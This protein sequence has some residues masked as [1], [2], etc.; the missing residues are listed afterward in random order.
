LDKCIAHLNKLQ[1]H[2]HCPEKECKEQLCRIYLSQYNIPECIKCLENYNK[3]DSLYM[4]K[5][6]CKID[7]CAKTII[8]E[9]QSIPLLQT[10]FVI[11]QCIIEVKTNGNK[12]KECFAPIKSILD[13]LPK[14]SST[15][16]I[17]KF[18]DIMKNGGEY[19]KEFNVYNKQK[20]RLEYKFTKAVLLQMCL[21]KDC[22]QK[23][24]K[25]AKEKSDKTLGAYK[26][27]WKIHKKVITKLIEEKNSQTYI[28]TMNPLH[29][30]TVLHY[31]YVLHID[32]GKPYDAKKF[33]SLTEKLY[34]ND[35]LQ[36][37]V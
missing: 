26:R 32:E 8:Q 23:L 24:Y 12:L 34:P 20:Q 28:M 3:K 5:Q 10:Q 15:Y 2:K 37:I 18:L 30:L 27:S 17:F 29:H 16:K 6:L 31:S 25:G 9:L 14:E 36:T 21:K 22:A 35:S 1:A 4:F 7:E 33:K 13:A 11:A 19:S